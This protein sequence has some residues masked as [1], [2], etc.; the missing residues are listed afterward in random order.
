MFQERRNQHIHKLEESG[1]QVME[2]E[3]AVS[4]QKAMSKVCSICDA[5]FICQTDVDTH[6]EM[7]KSS[8]AQVSFLITLII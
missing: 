1:R 5:A 7:H 3:T 8:W 6:Q 4:S 2:G